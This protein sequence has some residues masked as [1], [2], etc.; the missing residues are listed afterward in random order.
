MIHTSAFSTAMM[1]KRHLLNF[2]RY[3]NLYTCIMNADVLLYLDVL[4]EHE[5]DCVKMV[6]K[7]FVS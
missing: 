1:A 2:T 6:E 5:K 4:L 7:A 3:V